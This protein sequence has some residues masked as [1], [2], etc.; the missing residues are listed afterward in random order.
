MRPGPRPSPARSRTRSRPGWT[1]SPGC[2]PPYGPPVSAHRPERT[3]GQGGPRRPSRR[4]PRVPERSHPAAAARPG[5]S[6]AS[7][8]SNAERS[9]VRTTGRGRRH[10]P[11]SV[12]AAGRFGARIRS[13]TTTSR[14]SRWST[15]NPRRGSGRS[16]QNPRGGGSPREAIDASRPHRPR[17]DRPPAGRSARP[18][19]PA[20]T[21]RS[22]TATLRPPAIDP[23]RRT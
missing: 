13:S 11:P 4:V 5:S 6:V 21:H 12:P 2:G 19:R 1:M 7:G 3:H 23:P 20:M 8:R 22:A 15:A 18:R 9:A 17:R 10:R 14:R 16:P